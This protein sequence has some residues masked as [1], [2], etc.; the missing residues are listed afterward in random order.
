MQ[1]FC[2]A[3]K[4]FQRQCQSEQNFKESKNK[5][6]KTYQKPAWLR[7]GQVPRLSAQCHRAGT[8]KWR[9]LLAFSR[10]PPL[11]LPCATTSNYNRLTQRDCVDSRSRG[12]LEEATSKKDVGK[13]EMRLVDEVQNGCGRPRNVNPSTGYKVDPIIIEAYRDPTPQSFISQPIS[14]LFGL[15]DIYIYKC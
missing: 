6:E 10:C 2:P 1:A 15:F 5:K 9:H 7:K 13:N 11:P 3:S 4:V 12:G 14:L 8:K